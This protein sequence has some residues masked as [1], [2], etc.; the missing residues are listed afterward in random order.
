MNTPSLWLL[1]GSQHLYGAEALRQ[2]DANARAIA[3]ALDA[4]HAHMRAGLR[5]KIVAGH[6]ESPRVRAQ[7]GA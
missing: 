7:L 4:A 3:A 6:R 5:R 2:M 1:T